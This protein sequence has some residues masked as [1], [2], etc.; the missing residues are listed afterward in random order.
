M[1]AYQ[2]L[3][4]LLIGILVV[5][6]LVAASRW[7]RKEQGAL[8]HLLARQAEKR[9]GEV[10]PAT[11]LYY[12]KL[13]LP[14]DGAELTASALVGGRKTDRR[15]ERTYVTFTLPVAA[16]NAFR[17]TKKTKSLQALVDGKLSGSQIRTGD[18]AFDEAFRVESENDVTTLHFLSEEVRRSLLAFEET[19]DVRFDRS[20]FIVK[21]DEIVDREATLDRMIDLTAQAHDALRYLATGTSG[22][23]NQGTTA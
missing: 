9:G 10:K 1:T 5:A 17:I 12:P 19:V 8:Y 16:G 3:L 14:L 21:V 13:T 22:A 4:L 20:H 7:K 2:P 11:L 18:P 23:R 15:P 6:A